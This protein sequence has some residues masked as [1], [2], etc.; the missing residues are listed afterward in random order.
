MNK[1]ADP[2]RIRV[3]MKISFNFWFAAG[4]AMLAIAS[5]ATQAQQLDPALAGK[6]SVAVVGPFTT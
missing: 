5:G 3:G 2:E 6:Y 1:E 4:V